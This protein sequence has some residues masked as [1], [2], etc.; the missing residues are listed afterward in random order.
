MKMKIYLRFLPVFF[1]IAAF[2]TSFSQDASVKVVEWTFSAAATSTNEY[3]ISIKGIIQPGWKLFSTLMSDDDPNTRVKL[4]SATAPFASIENITESSN[5]RQLKEPLFDNKEIKYFEKNVELKILLA[6]KEK[7]HEIKGTVTYM[8]LKGQEVAG[9]EEIPF[10]FSLD[11]GGNLV[12]KAAGIQESSAGNQSIKRALIDIKNPAEK[13]GGTGAED[14]AS[15]SLWGIF[16]LG[17]HSIDYALHFPDD[18]PYCF[19]FYKK[20]RNPF[21]GNF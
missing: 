2:F 12:A 18:T 15:K 19:F 16:L 13:C 1:F 3:T 11:A 5:L 9:P 21:K 14:N 10:R 8:A 17:F 20:I 7:S 4:D 6:L